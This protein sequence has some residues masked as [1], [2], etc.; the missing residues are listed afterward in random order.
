MHKI[1]KIQNPLGQIGWDWKGDLRKRCSD[2]T[3]VSCESEE[4]NFSVQTKRNE[5]PYYHRFDTLVTFNLTI[6]CANKNTIQTSL[7]SPL[8][9]QH[10]LT[11]NPASVVFFSFSKTYKSLLRFIL[12]Y[13][14]LKADYVEANMTIV[15]F[16]SLSLVAKC[17]NKKYTHLM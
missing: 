9:T 5:S 11:Y 4:A 14:T 7:N 10:T 12:S 6:S 8:I 15:V 17:Y 16:F 13:F 2:V 3:R 1:R